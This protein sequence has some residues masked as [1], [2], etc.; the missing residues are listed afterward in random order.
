L[1]ANDALT[2]LVASANQI[3]AESIG[4]FIDVVSL[5][6]LGDQDRFCLVLRSAP[7]RPD[8]TIMLDNVYRASIQK[9]PDAAGSFVDE[10]WVKVLPKAPAS[11]P[12]AAEALA[13]RH[14][15]LPGLIWLKV[16]ANDGRR[17]CSNGYRFDSTGSSMTRRNAAQPQ[18]T[19]V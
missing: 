8:I 5:Q 11:W 1:I 10:A 17:N 14:E 3:L 9:P 13:A 18:M 19:V 4:A 12:A 2:V 15:H 6:V 16:L 7:T